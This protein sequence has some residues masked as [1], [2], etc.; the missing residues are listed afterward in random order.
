MNTPS[1]A[2]P[3][4]ILKAL[5]QVRAAVPAV[6][7]SGHNAFHHYD[8][9]SESDVLSAYNPAMNEAGLIVLP[10]VLESHERQIQTKSGGETTL[11]RVVMEFT[12]AHKDG[13]VWPV[14]LRWEAQ[15]EDSQDKGLAKAVTSATKYF[16]TSLF[17]AEKGTDPDADSGEGTKKA[18]RTNA[19]P[20]SAPIPVASA[21]VCPK[22][23]KEAIAKGT[24][25][26]GGGWFCSKKKGGCGA[27]FSAW[28]PPVESPV[29]PASAVPGQGNMAEAVAQGTLPTGLTETEMKTALSELADAGE[30]SLLDVG[31]Y[32]K[33]A[34]VAAL[35]KR[36][37]AEQLDQFT[38]SKND[39]K[40]Y[41]TDKGEA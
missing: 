32:W 28:P 31:S 1:V 12:L 2:Y 39:W 23:G 30:K 20:R 9:A 37:S 41:W 19:V 14:P 15:G 22:C 40:Q 38:I 4:S 17:Q 24:E 26:Y 18:P 5:A 25:Q 34:E 6:P 10:A 13:D 35:R 7:K 21:K 11:T 16:L 29:P 33:L 27:K 36:M 3:P 8:Y